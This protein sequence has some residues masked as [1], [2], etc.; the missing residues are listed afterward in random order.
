MALF[1]SLDHKSKPY[2]LHHTEELFL[3][4]I[5]RYNFCTTQRR[6]PAATPYSST[7]QSTQHLSVCLGI[8]SIKNEIKL[9][10]ITYKQLKHDSFQ[11]FLTTPYRNLFKRMLSNYCG[12][13]RRIHCGTNTNHGVYS[14]L[15]MDASKITCWLQ[16][17]KTRT[18]T[19]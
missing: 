10:L 5:K 18:T 14:R 2:L 3:R 7:F 1:L 6:T 13:N 16:Q 11:V 4:W 12:S 19:D 9:P 17:P 15:H 8:L